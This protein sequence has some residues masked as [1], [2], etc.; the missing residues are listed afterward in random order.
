MQRNIVL[1]TSQRVGQ[2]FI[3]NIREH[4]DQSTSNTDLPSQLKGRPL[5][6]GH[7]LSVRVS[8]GYFTLERATP[9][10]SW[11]I[12]TYKL[13]VEIKDTGSHT[14]LFPSRLRLALALLP[15]SRE[16]EGGAE[17]R[18]AT[19]KTNTCI[20]T[21]GGVST[22]M[23]R[24]IVL[25]TSQRVGQKFI[26]N[27]RE[28]TDQ[29]TS[30]TDLPSQLKGRP[31]TPGHSLSVRVSPGYFTLERATPPNSWAIVTYKLTVE[32]KDTGSHTPLFPSRLR[33]AL[34]L[35]PLSTAP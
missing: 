30:N 27:I 5:T 12:V 8:P 21:T 34:A 28:H 31:L 23:Q 16:V 24:N 18:N 2:K 11:A 13:T 20:L 35:L 26:E 4:T 3:E 33:L 25:S 10:N 19:N 7:S 15:L 6:P 22:K 17:N 9:P 32:I 29:S 14:P 1:S